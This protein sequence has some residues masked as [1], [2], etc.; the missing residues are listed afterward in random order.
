[1]KN[2]FGSPNSTSSTRTIQKQ[3]IKARKYFFLVV[4]LILLQWELTSAD[5]ESVEGLLADNIDHRAP[6]NQPL[7]TKKK[8]YPLADENVNGNNVFKNKNTQASKAQKLHEFQAQKHQK[9]LN[10][11]EENDLPRII[12][13]SRGQKASSSAI[14]NILASNE[15]RAR[16]EYAS[17]LAERNINFLNERARPPQNQG[18]FAKSTSGNN[19]PESFKGKEKDLSRF[20]PD[21]IGRISYRGNNGKP[22]RPFGK[23]LQSYP[24]IQQMQQEN[25]QFH[26]PIQYQKS[27]LYNN[28]NGEKFMYPNEFASIRN[29]MPND[30]YNEK[31]IKENQQKVIKSQKWNDRINSMKEMSPPSNKETKKSQMANSAESSF[32]FIHFQ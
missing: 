23:F 14:R 17:D 12:S 32:R 2:L 9:L 25:S 22:S 11:I 27:Q 8:Q 21:T 29:G 13:S 3:K 6:E 7:K 16:N 5:P 31:Q 1:M 28:L 18:G 15:A 19:F 10:A 26:L 30:A 4:S 20:H 24:T